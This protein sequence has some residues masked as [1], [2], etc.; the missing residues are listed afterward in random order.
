M[1][2]V[3]SRP[4]LKKWLDVRLRE[5]QLIVES[6]GKNFDPNFFVYGQN[7]PNS[8]EPKTIV[9]GITTTPVSWYKCIRCEC[10]GHEMIECPVRFFFI[11][12]RRPL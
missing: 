12:I 11:R 1:P 7:D 4:I 10:N 9:R 2:S 6:F 3:L 5:R 8:D